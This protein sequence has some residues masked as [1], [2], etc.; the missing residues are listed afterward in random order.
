MTA[1]I[2]TVTNK[3]RPVNY[4]VLGETKEEAVLA[5]CQETGLDASAILPPIKA[6]PGILERVK[7][8]GKKVRQLRL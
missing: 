2:I 8:G 3:K 7:F 6:D 1:F 4:V 5:F